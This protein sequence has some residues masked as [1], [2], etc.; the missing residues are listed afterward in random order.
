MGTSAYSSADCRSYVSIRSPVSGKSSAR[1]LARYPIPV[2]IL[3]R[4]GVDFS[5]QG[6]G[7]GSALVRDALL[8]VAS[9]AQHVG[10]RARRNDPHRT[11]AALGRAV[12]R[13][14]LTR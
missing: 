1:G 13:P 8:Q 6:R 7:L 5:E 10:V 2:V 14:T 11:T 4:L 3:I 9:I 12:S